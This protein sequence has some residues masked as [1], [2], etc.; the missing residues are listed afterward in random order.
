M[1]IYIFYTDR[2]YRNCNEIMARKEM[3]IKYN[4]I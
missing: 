3:I 1:N 2:Q 4:P